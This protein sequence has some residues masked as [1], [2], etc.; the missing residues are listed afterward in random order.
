MAQRDY[1]EERSEAISRRHFMSQATVAASV[2]W[3]SLNV[4]AGCTTMPGQNSRVSADSR[5][6]NDDAMDEALVML[7]KSG[8]EYWGGLANHGPMAAEAW[9]IGAPIGVP[10]I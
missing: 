6:G 5:E 9:L 7:A 10:W 4:L 2:S 1:S 3:L 8:P